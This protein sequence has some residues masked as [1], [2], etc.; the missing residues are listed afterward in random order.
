[1]QTSEAA[2]IA[3]TLSLEAMGPRLAEIRSMTERSLLSH[4]MDGGSLHLVYRP[5][6]EKEL[7]RI[8]GLEQ[9]CCAFLDFSLTSN[10]HEVTLTITAPSDAG[11]AAHWLFAQFLP[12]TAVPD[13]PAASCGC[14]SRACAA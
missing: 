9:V 2:A 10:E 14:R 5:D 11:S 3:C 4:C 8:V 12:D 13:T 6:A 1:M 7:R